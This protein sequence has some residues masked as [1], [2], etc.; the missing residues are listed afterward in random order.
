MKLS[1]A[2]F[3][4]DR[5]VSFLGRWSLLA[6]A[7]H[8]L[9]RDALDRL[10]AEA[11]RAAGGEEPSWES[12]EGPTLKA[13]ELLLRSQTGALFAG[14][15]V[16]VVHRAE[17]IPPAEQEALAKAVG[18]LPGDVAV[19]LVTAES[20][21]RR[22]QRALRASLQRAIE[23][24]GLWIEFAPLKGAEAEAWA[25]ARAQEYGKRLERAAA[26]KL[27]EQKLGTSL[28]ELENEVA[29]LASYVGERPTITSADV[30]EV[31]PRLVEEDIFRLTDAVATQQ[32]AR[33]VSILRAMLRDRREAPMGMLAMIAQAIREIWQFKV[34]LDH[35]WRPGRQPSEEV[36]A[37]LPSGPRRNALKRIAGRQWQVR[38]RINQANSFSWSRLTRALRALNDCDSAMKGMASKVSDA[39]M[40]I[41]LLV[42]QLCRDLEMPLWESRSGRAGRRLERTR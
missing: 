32:P 12:L 24:H 14:V 18:E 40:A 17:R 34:L 1:Y 13:A 38:H 35:G 29:K 36:T 3:A 4:T 7:E 9:K 41:E 10:R 21:P 15:R 20:G 11:V 22:G 27:A 39:D 16:V 33:A 8:R 19:A 31:T 2:K 28:A 25:M 5:K 42:V 26:R 37:L 30:D 6:G 23:K